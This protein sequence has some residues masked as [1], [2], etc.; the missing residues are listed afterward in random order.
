[1]HP[2]LIFGVFQTSSMKMEYSLILLLLFFL[3]VDIT[4]AT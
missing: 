4:E 1:M 2:H 3:G